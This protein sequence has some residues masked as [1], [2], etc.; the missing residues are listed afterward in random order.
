MKSKFQSMEIPVDL[1]PWRNGLCSHPSL[2]S[3]LKDHSH[4][5]KFCLCNPCPLHYQL[6]SGF[7][8]PTH[9]Y[10]HLIALIKKNKKI[11]P[12]IPGSSSATWPF[13][14][15]FGRF[16]PAC[17]CFLLLLLDSVSP[18]PT[19]NRVKIS[20]LYRASSINSPPSS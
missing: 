8:S 9:T 6:P 4:A 15:L 7:L 18:V 16:L 17:L 20:L 5:F 3:P 19:P 11:S 13:H 1:S 10:K 12:L 2:V 14:F